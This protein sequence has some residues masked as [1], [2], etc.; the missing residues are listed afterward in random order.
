M[1]R[2]RGSPQNGFSAATCFSMLHHVPSVDEQD[3]VFAEVSRL[4]RPGAPFLGVDSLDLD[5][6]REFHVDDIFMPMDP[7]KLGTRLEAAGFTD[8]AVD[9]TELELRFY[10]RKR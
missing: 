6:I 8:V 2:R 3:R 10:G 1:R 4:L 5:F 9:K 7:D